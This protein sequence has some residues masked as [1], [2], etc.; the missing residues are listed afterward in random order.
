MVGDGTHC[1]LQLV[2]G[3]LWIAAEPECTT[4]HADDEGTV[5]IE[6]N[7]GARFGDGGLPFAAPHHHVCQHRM[8]HRIV[9]VERY[10]DVRFF[11]RGSLNLQEGA[12]RE[13]PDIPLEGQRI[14]VMAG[15]E[16]RIECDS[17]AEDGLRG[18]VF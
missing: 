18:L 13:V 9:V 7:R 16:I 10:R 11:T 1:R 2:E 5:W 6:G 3:F 4:K 17:L 8:R 15:S 14:S 12:I